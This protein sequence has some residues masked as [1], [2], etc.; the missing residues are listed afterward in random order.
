MEILRQMGLINKLQRQI[1]TKKREKSLF[2]EHP[3]GQKTNPPFRVLVV[4]APLLPGAKRG[5]RRRKP[6]PLPG[7][8]PMAAD[9]GYIV[10][11]ALPLDPVFL[12]VMLRK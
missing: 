11:G 2:F 8:S 5:Q 12:P 7:I 1:K 9:G 3:D 4:D 6:Q 10:T